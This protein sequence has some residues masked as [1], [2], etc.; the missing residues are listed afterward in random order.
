MRL[1]R[2]EAL[3]AQF[4]DIESD[5]SE[6]EEE[7]KDQIGELEGS[8]SPTNAIGLISSND[9]IQVGF[10][11]EPTTTSNQKPNPALLRLNLVRG[12][13]EKYVVLVN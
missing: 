7:E 10:N 12:E 9:Q 2:A 13:P 3:I 8:F 4:E 1:D 11:V 6:I 5:P